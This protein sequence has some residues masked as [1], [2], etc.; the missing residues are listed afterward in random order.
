MR[1]FRRTHV[2]FSLCV[3]FEKISLDPRCHFAAILL[4]LTMCSKR[5]KFC[6]APGNN[7]LQLLLY[8]DENLPLEANALIFDL[9]FLCMDNK[10]FKLINGCP[11]KV[12]LFEK[13]LKFDNIANV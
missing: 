3:Y 2:C 9:F 12:L 4:V 8:G 10:E 5:T 11:K 6:E 1:S 13:S 7:I